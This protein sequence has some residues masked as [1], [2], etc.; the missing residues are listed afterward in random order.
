[1]GE[2]AMVNS[3]D[4]GSLVEFTFNVSHLHRSDYIRPPGLYIASTICVPLTH[5]SL[6]PALSLTPK[7]LFFRSLILRG[8]GI[9]MWAMVCGV[10]VPRGGCY[11]GVTKSQSS[12]DCYFT[13]YYY[14]T[15]YVWFWLKFPLSCC[16][17]FFFFFCYPR[18]TW[19][20]SPWETW[21][22]WLWSLSGPLRSPTASG[23]CT[24][25]R[26][27]LEGNQRWNVTLLEKLSTCLT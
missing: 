23:C 10:S 9:V 20:D 12:P 5:I 22:P 3:S 18:W 25:P 17:C 2:S 19:E 26:L 24:W 16:W 11:L 21:G 6:V 14:F 1:M 8:E 15:P 13:P 27:L 4:V 7:L